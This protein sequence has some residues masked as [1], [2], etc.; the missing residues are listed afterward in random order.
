MSHSRAIV[1]AHPRLY[2]TLSAISTRDG[3]GR[4]LARRYSAA[5]MVGRGGATLT[6]SL[7]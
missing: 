2:T 5:A 6:A 7:P 3:T 4:I 1:T